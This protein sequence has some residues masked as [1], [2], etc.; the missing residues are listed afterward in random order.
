MKGTATLSTRQ[1]RI[2]AVIRDFTSEYGYPPT[3]RQIGE[4]VGISST[5]VVSYNLSVLQ[6]KGYLARDREV[7]RGLRLVGDEGAE[8]L[9][10]RTVTVPVLGV[11]AAG[12]P[13]PIPDGDFGQIDA[14]TLS[15]PEDIVAD[16][17]RVYALEVRGTSMIDALIDDGDIVIMRHQQ[18]AENGDM[19]AAWLKD[20]KATTLKRIYWERDRSLVR[21]QPANP[22][23][24]PIYVHP[25]DLEIQG[26]VVG[27]IRR[28]A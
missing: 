10:G 8:E 7:S 20:E 13:I 21:L 15:L 12:E 9:A 24:D 17:D 2:L 5:S 4:A 1:R 25:D 19:V 6:R 22:L 18:T 27:V 14:D 26:R 3:I 11:I 23:M 16:S 28:L